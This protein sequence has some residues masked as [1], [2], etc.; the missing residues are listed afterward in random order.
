[1]ARTTT[2][3]S[4]P[5]RGREMMGFLEGLCIS[6][7]WQILAAVSFGIDLFSVCVTSQDSNSCNHT[8]I[9]DVIKRLNQIYTDSIKFYLNSKT[10][11]EFYFSFEFC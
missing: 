9:V 3:I 4:T 10:R 8:L 7:A 5:K 2:A 6:A 1:M 11:T